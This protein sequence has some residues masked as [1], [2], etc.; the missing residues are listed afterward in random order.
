[1]WVH[2][3]HKDLYKGNE[4]GRRMSEVSCDRGSSGPSKVAKRP[5]AKECVQC[6]ASREGKEVNSLLD[7]SEG[8][9]SCQHFISQALDSFWTFAP[10][11]DKKINCSFSPF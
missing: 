8:A 3:I 5:E 11:N 7:P 10:H 9:Q 2:Y 4:G 6:L 1:M